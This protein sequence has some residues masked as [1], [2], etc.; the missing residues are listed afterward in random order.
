MKKKLLTGRV[1]LAVCLVTAA[2]LWTSPAPALAVAPQ[3]SPTEEIPCGPYE[4]AECRSV[5]VCID[6]W[7]IIKLCITFYDYYQYPDPS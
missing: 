7:K 4:D 2:V 5:G 6:V 3:D 1:A